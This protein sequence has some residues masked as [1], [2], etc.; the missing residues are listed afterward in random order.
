MKRCIISFAGLIAVN[1]LSA[2]DPHFSQ[3][4]SNPV[5]L[6]PA[7]TGIHQCQLRVIGHERVQ[8]DPVVP[9]QNYSISME[10]NIMKDDRN[11]GFAGIGMQ[12]MNDVQ[13]SEQA[14][15]RTSVSFSAAFVLRLDQDPDQL[16]SLGSNISFNQFQ[17]WRESFNFEPPWISNPQADPV[18]GPDYLHSYLDYNVGLFWYRSFYDQDMYA[19]ISLAHIGRPNQTEL[20]IKDA[21]VERKLTF[22]GGGHTVLSR[23]F[24]MLPSIVLQFQDPAQ[25]FNMGSWVQYVT[26]DNRYRLG[27]GVWKRFVSEKFSGAGIDAFI[28]G[29][30]AG[31]FNTKISITY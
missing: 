30:R 22:H 13:G 5:Y 4:N 31:M 3:F 6:N 15:M 12:F 29:L 27:F 17:L 9:F 20:G 26:E 8:W 7:M 18:V 21:V 10:G 28:L 24:E 23:H 11:R 19:G 2:Q 25:Q 14:F 1:L 16:L